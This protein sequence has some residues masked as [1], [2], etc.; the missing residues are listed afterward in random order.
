ML[1]LGNLDARRDWGYAAE[2][3]EAMWL[4][5]QQDQPDDYVI[6]TGESHTVRE[7]CEVA[8]EHAGLDWRAPRP[9]R[10]RYYRPP[11]STTCCGDASKAR[12]ELGWK[13]P[14]RLRRS[15]SRLMVDADVALLEDE[16]AG[17]T[18]RIDRP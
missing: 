18:V 9:D 1:Y 17:R 4:M 5:L 8:F 16:L 11:R 14:D 6:A 12:G 3:V 15:W 7:F 2:Y 13:P 10:P